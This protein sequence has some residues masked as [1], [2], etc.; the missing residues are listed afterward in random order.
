MTH[1]KPK[2]LYL[3]G[4]PMGVGKS[5]VGREL[6]HLLPDC[7]HLEGDALWDAD[8]FHVTEE[9]RAMVLRNITFVLNE[10]LHCSAYAHI[11]FTWVMHEQTF[12]DTITAGLH[13]HGATVIP[14]SLLASPNTLR[15]RLGEDIRK[16]SRTEDVIARSLQRLTGFDTVNTTKIHTDNRT[17]EAIAA[18]IADLRI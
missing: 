6:K 5:A 11:V 14:V 9:T 2:T 13:L 15:Q 3:I 12:I 1:P 10:F 7:V 16:G 18:E 4:G 8:P 17:P